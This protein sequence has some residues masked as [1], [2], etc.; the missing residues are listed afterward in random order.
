M[1]TN[2]VPTFTNHTGN[3]T[4]GPFNIGFNFIDRNEVIVRVNEVL[5]STPTHYTFNSGTQITFTSG[6]EPATGVNIELRRSTNITTAKVDFEDGSVLTETDLDANTNQ[7][8]FA[9]QE[10]TD[11]VNA[12]NLESSSIY[13]RD[14]SRTLTGNIVFEGST[15]DAH[16]TTLTPVDPTAD[17]TINI[18]NVSGTLVTTGDT[19]TV[20]STMIAN[21]TIVNVDIDSSAAIAGTK[22]SPSFGSQNIFTTGNV[23]ASSFIGD[24]SQ[25]TGITFTGIDQFLRR[26]IDDDCLGKIRFGSD[27]TFKTAIVEGNTETSMNEIVWEA[28]A[29]KMTWDARAA[30]HTRGLHIEGDVPISHNSRGGNS[31]DLGGFIVDPR[32]GELEITQL[33]GQI[34]IKTAPYGLPRTVPA[35][36]NHSNVVQWNSF[37]IQGTFSTDYSGDQ[38]DYAPYDW[39]LLKQNTYSLS[40]IQS[41]NGFDQE[42]YLRSNN[43]DILKVHKTGVD[44]VNGN[45]N[46]PDNGKFQ[47]GDSQ[48]LQIY[49]DGSH[50]VVKDAGTGQ[51]KLLGSTIAIKNGNDNK[52]SASFSPNTACNL[53]YN[54]SKKFETT[55]TGTT[56]SGIALAGGIGTVGFKVPDSP[57][58]TNETTT[59]GMFIAGTGD[60]L[61]ISHSGTDSFITNVTGNLHIQP[62]AS[63]EGIKLIPDGAVELYYDN[64]KKFETTSTGVTVTGDAT[65]SG[66]LDLPDGSDI[67][68]GND[69]DFRIYHDNSNG[70]NYIQ[71]H[72][73]GPLILKANS[74]NLAKFIPDGS[75]E[76]YHD[77]SKKFET[78]ST[79]VLIN[80]H[81]NLPDQVSGTGKIKLGDNNDLQLYHDGTDSFIQNSTGGL[82][83]LGDTI[84]LKANSTDENMLVA[85][86][87]SSVSLYFD[88]ALHFKTTS[89]GAQVLGTLLVG[90]HLRAASDA[91]RISAGA[92]NDLEIFHNGANSFVA[93]KQDGTGN[94]YI[95]S[96]G[97]KDLI[98]RSG[99]GTSG[100]QLSIL[101]TA[102][103]ATSLYFDAVKKIETTSTGVRVHGDI[104]PEADNTRALGASS[105]RF[106]TLHSAA[107][108]TGDINMSNLN[109]NANEVDGSRGSW[110]LQ[111]GADDLFIINRVSGKKYKF[112]LTE[113]N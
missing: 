5:K 89:Y 81:I 14:G 16:E 46:A 8:L 31:D 101:C 32:P 38:G 57:S 88:N 113:I 47:F 18:P 48:D 87:N 97:T 111:E 43:T 77:S 94:L 50:S 40:E 29:G 112:N 69:D 74:D 21:G 7:L 27:V 107:L 78:T 105:K 99:N 60:D 82:K 51:L 28:Q 45:L 2:T 54:N 34:K 85:N 61:R 63:E 9:L 83:I 64:S 20:T 56:T 12:N 73:N 25:L 10:N 39:L 72:N 22:I 70:L 98:L 49:H 55:S 33:L 76:L 58:V 65:F 19:G 84:R 30:A 67:L 11:A 23:T 6:N 71:A 100:A 35:Y 96:R 102:E 66:N 59:H 95:E 109:D 86:V 103:G 108:N 62:K 68:L 75:V 53:F 44:L 52:L 92:D 15:K 93:Q 104:V 36:T 13:L 41:A 24:G 106:T 90:G 37:A 42:M 80:G 4:A 91:G 79:G 26:D 3:G 110:T 17:R 1:A